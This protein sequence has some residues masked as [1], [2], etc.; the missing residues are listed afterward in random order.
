MA[1][2]EQT[3]SDINYIL[4]SDTYIR[5]GFRVT[6]S[7]RYISSLSFLLS[8][9][10]NPTGNVTFTIRKTSD[11][12]LLGSKVWGDASGLPIL[13][14]RDWKQV[15]FDSPVYVN[16]E[17]RL[18][19]EYSGGDSP[20]NIFC[21]AENS[22]IKANEVFTTYI[23]GYT[24]DDA[25]DGAYSYEY[26]G[27]ETS[28]P[29]VTTQ[30][31]TDVASTTATA[32]GNVTDLGAPLATQHGHVWATHPKPT[33]DDNMTENGVP[34]A[35]GAYT[36][37][38]T[39]LAPNTL[40][41]CRAYVESALG[42]FYSN[43]PVTFTSDS[44]TATVTT[45][46]VTNFAVLS[47]TGNGTIV[48][49]GGSAITAYGVCWLT[50]TD[51]IT[52]PTTSDDLTDHGAT[53]VLGDFSSLMTGLTANTSYRVRAYVTTALGTSYGVGVSFTTNTAG[54]PIVLALPTV[55]ITPT[56]AT[57][58]GII[59]SLGGSAVTQHGHCWST[60]INPTTSD[61]KTSLGTGSADEVFTS[62]ISSLTKGTPYY[63]RPYATNTQGT[64]Y[65]DNELINYDAGGVAPGDDPDDTKR[66]IALL[67][68]YLV[69]SDMV[70]GSQRAV[71]GVKF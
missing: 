64:S 51:P 59:K 50:L 60:S 29:T 25:S 67:D 1:T 57:G 14:E 47:A 4:A 23:S 22:D 65:G 28:S 3:T 40:Y 27:G 19:C 24:D 63:I 7:S 6:I 10:N 69:Y 52:E 48:S 16:E 26:S 12:S 33:T 39:N 61:S 11:D 54:M 66:R 2:E 62:L 41:Y 45:R 8:Q 5:V 68:E 42:T 44:S 20:I 38:L 17:V 37:S 56:T 49:D 30:A 58:K 18:L 21:G 36:S 71:L 70:D 32:N 46:P 53:T 35:T 15:T 13:D 43:T 9:R 34:S 31:A 55:D